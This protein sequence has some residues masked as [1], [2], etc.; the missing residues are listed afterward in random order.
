MSSLSWASQNVLLVL[1]DQSSLLTDLCTKALPADL[2]YVA[3]SNPDL[4]LLASTTIMIG[5]PDKIVRYLSDA[6]ALKWVQSTWAGVTPLMNHS[7]RDYQ[8]TVLKGVFGQ[9]M[10]EYVLGWILALEREIS[11][12][13]QDSS[14]NQR[15]PVT[16]LGKRLGIMGTG[17]IACDVAIAAKALGL[18]V[19]GFNRSGHCPPAFE[20]CFTYEQRLDFAKD[21][22]YLLCVMPN[23]TETDDLV[24]SDL[25]YAIAPHAILLNTGRGNCVDEDALV[26]V[27]DSGHLRAAVL[28]VFKQEPLPP[29]HRFWSHPKVYVTSHTS[30]PTNIQAA[31]DVFEQ[32][33]ERFLNHQP[34][35]YVVDFAKGY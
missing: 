34:L 26:Q 6:P 35:L 25:L 4:P 2:R 28:D 22:D 7:R 5:A 20:S 11:D 24:S 9:V 10:S 21:L 8:L 19:T 30:A 32:N 3:S 18:R 1:D 29:T 14:W 12:Y 15:A 27:L 23:T 16:I 17:D 13:A 31:V 33:L